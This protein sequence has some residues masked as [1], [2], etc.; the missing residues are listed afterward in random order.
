MAEK[1]KTDKIREVAKDIMVRFK[2]IESGILSEHNIKN[3]IPDPNL[4]ISVM[5]Y[6]TAD[7]KFIDNPTQYEF[8]LTNKG[9]NFK[10]FEDLDNNE[11]L[12][13]EHR[14]DQFD[15]AKS[16]IRANILNEK[17][18][19][20][21]LAFTITNVVIGVLNAILLI[22]QLYKSGLLTE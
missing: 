11:K 15:L 21:N 9:K 2:N 22:W 7:L 18:S 20:W 3:F 19:K 14:Q 8:R 10:S 13:L 5:S 17:N 6:L 4:R 1:E 16:N 12:T